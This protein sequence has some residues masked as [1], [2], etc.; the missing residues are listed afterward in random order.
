VTATGGFTVTSNEG[1]ASGLQTVA[2]FAD[3]GGSEE[4]SDYAASISWGDGTPN[5]PGTITVSGGVYT[6]QGSHTYAEESTPDHTGGSPTYK[7]TVTISHDAAAA[8]TAVSAAKVTD[9]PVAATG[10]F[11]VTG[12]EGV[13]SSSQTVATFTDPGGAE[14]VGD[15]AATIAWGDGSTSPGTITLSGGVYTVAGSHS[16][17]EENAPDHAGSNPYGI[18]VTVTHEGAP[19]VTATSTAVIGDATPVA[20]AITGPATASPGQLLTWGAPFT[21]TGKLDTHTGTFSWGDS[22]S[23]TVAAVESGGSGTVSSTH[24]YVAAGTYTISLTVADDDGT[25]SSPVFFT[26]TVGG[27]TMLIL[28]PKASGAVTISGDA[29]FT[30]A[31]PLQVDSKSK[32]AINAS[33]HASLTA[34]SINVVGG[35]DIDGH[36]SLHPTPHTGAAFVPDPLAK[37]PTPVV[38]GPTMRVDIGGHTALTIKPGI[39]SEIEVSG[40]ASLMMLPGIYDIAGGGFKVSGHGKVAGTNVFIYN[41][42]SNDSDDGHDHDD[43]DDFGGIS[44]SGNALLTL[45]PPAAGQ[46]YAGILIFQA[47]DND[48]T[49]SVS[50]NGMAGSAGMIYAPAAL[51]DLS[52]NGKL[53]N[54]NLVVDRLRISG[55]DDD[56]DGGDNS[57]T[58]TGGNSVSTAPGTLLARNLVVYVDNSNGLFTPGE[59][60]R[61]QA[62]VNGLNSLL[63]PYNVTITMVDAANS[64]LANI[65]LEV[66]ATTDLGGVAQGVLGCETEAGNI[67]LVSGWNWNTSADPSQVGAYQY[68]FQ[69]VVTHELGHALGLGH[70]ADPS[71]VMYATLSPGVA[72][73]TM[74]TADLNLPDVAETGLAHPLLAAP[75]NVQGRA[76]G[77]P[78]NLSVMAG[79]SWT[80]NRFLVPVD[81]WATGALA[82]D[83]GARRNDMAST[84]PLVLVDN[85]QTSSWRPDNA[86]STYA[87]AIGELSTGKPDDVRAALDRIDDRAAGWM[88]VNPDLDAGDSAADAYAAAL[89]RSGDSSDGD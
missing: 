75:F 3:P 69:T 86:A 88:L 5:T 2:T 42:R 18:T 78:V 25:K 71:S 22:T 14:A 52:G 28:D 27:Q 83:V 44:I 60:A 8:S 40:D 6:V 12:V 19:S 46:A 48:R 13:L 53:N 31:E 51:V 29:S 73:R 56:D 50:G 77:A 85:Q 67:T 72:R 82:G 61:L 39:Y 1:A 37:L 68:D 4:L 58:V 17:A 62:A 16:Y 80:L 23:T 49:I 59:L 79:A 45:T 20:G 65:T 43:D 47:R 11:T 74:T 66:A 15:Y 7:V 35:V 70:S 76:A 34:T 81:A 54:L 87:G 84:T 21:D 10:K 63:L 89:A 9:P 33:G 38:S 64:D 41:G 32:S 55:G 30:I 26:V 57:L 24:A 36:A